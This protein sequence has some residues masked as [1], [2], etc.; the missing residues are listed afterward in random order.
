MNSLQVSNSN[1]IHNEPTWD[2]CYLKGTE[3][4]AEHVSEAKSSESE[5]TEVRI[6][7]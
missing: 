7:F 1:L 5:T 2:H 4:T 6:F 3:F